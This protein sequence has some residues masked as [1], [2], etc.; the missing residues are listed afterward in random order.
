[1]EYLKRLCP[2]HIYIENEYIFKQ[3]E[4]KGLT[5]SITTTI[6]TTTNSSYKLINTKEEGDYLI[7]QKKLKEGTL[8]LEEKPY[9]FEVHKDNS[10]PNCLQPL[11]LLK[12]LIPCRRQKNC[13]WHIYYCS[14]LCE[15]Q[16]WFR[17]HMF[18]CRIPELKS[19]SQSPSTSILLAFQLYMN[20]IR[21][22]QQQHGLN[23][24]KLSSP[25]DHLIS[26]LQ[27]HTK[28]QQQLYEDQAKMISQLFLFSSLFHN[29]NNNN[30]EKSLIK[31]LIHYQAIIRCNGFGIQKK[32]INHFN[33]HT[34]KISV[35]TVAT[36]IY[37]LASKLNHS[38]QPNVLALFD[39]TTAILQLRTLYPIQ[40]N[41]PLSIS[42]GPLAANLSTL[43]RQQFLLD[44]YFFHCRCQ[45]CQVTITN[46]HDDSLP[47]SAEQIYKCTNCKYEKLKL[48]NKICPNCN[49]NINWIYLQKVE[50]E[51]EKYKKYGQLDKVLKL[52]SSIYRDLSLPI[53]NTY[54]QLAYTYHSVHHQP[55]IAAQFS[56]KSLTIVQSIYGSCS[57]EAA[58]EMFKL[59]GLL[60]S[61]AHDPSKLRYWIKKTHD[62]YIVLGLNHQLKQDFQ[63]LDSMLQMVS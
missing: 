57:P 39:N 12:S 56:E 44:H 7:S 55:I 4:N 9:A 28:E 42:Y 5:S 61:A 29:N 35:D 6:T 63:E 16:Y 41:E 60:Y 47:P 1:M 27:Y 45:A 32:L 38:C 51:I 53:G 48:E 31:A 50:Q 52:Q 24:N 13:S 11:L 37:P 34:N 25:I 15:A 59:C 43:K 54:D 19:S 49:N 23:R 14:I 3:Y 8:L 26:N 62:L 46:H 22:Q 17:V 40:P 33:D 10:C 2:T 30:E 18:V 58:E 36:G 21:Y 20:S